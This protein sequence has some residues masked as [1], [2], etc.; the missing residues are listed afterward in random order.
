MLSRFFSFDQNRDYEAPNLK[1]K[2]SYYTLHNACRMLSLRLNMPCSFIFK[3][4][5][6]LLLQQVKSDTWEQPP[7]PPSPFSVII[8]YP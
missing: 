3:I 5:V 7:V 2:T 6:S 4:N 8:A 1:Q